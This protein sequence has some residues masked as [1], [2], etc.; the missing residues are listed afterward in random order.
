VPLTGSRAEDLQGGER[1]GLALLTLR[2]KTDARSARVPDW[3]LA[4]LVAALIVTGA[5]TLFAGSPGAAWI[6]ACTT[7]ARLRSRSW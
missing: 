7:G 6:R 5:L 4:G 2:S 3:G 1:S